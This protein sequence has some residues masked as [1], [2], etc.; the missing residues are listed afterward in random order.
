MPFFPPIL[1]PADFRGPPF[2]KPQ[3]GKL[4]YRLH[5]VE[6]LGL[7]AAS[8]TRL[9]VENGEISDSFPFRVFHFFLS[10]RYR[11]SS[12][13]CARLVSPTIKILRVIHFAVGVGDVCYPLHRVAHPLKQPNF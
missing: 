13:I 6:K 7:L 9:G 4:P 8:S 3:K 10:L 2:T 5:F 11:A 1:L 12:R